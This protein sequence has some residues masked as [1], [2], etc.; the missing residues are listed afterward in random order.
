MGGQTLGYSAHAQL[1]AATIQKEIDSLRT[2][3][4]DFY[5][6]S[7]T[8]G[9]AP[10]YK[11][12]WIHVKEING[13]FHELKP[14]APEARKLMWDEFGLLCQR[15]KAHQSRAR[16]HSEHISERKRAI[17]FSKLDDA[18][19][20]VSVSTTPIDLAR[21]KELLNEA[22]GFM[23]DGWSEFNVSTQ[24]TALSDGRMTKNDH[25]KCWA[26][27]EDINNALHFRRRELGEHYC[28]TF[29]RDAFDAIDLAASNPRQ[30]KEAVKSI[31]QAMK[32]TVMSREQF[33]EV[34]RLLDEAWKRASHHQESRHSEWLER[35]RGNVSYKQSLIDKNEEYI[36]RL[37]AQI[38]KCQDMES[39]ARSEDFANTVRGWIEEKYDKIANVRSR[40]ADL[41]AEIRE[42]EHKLSG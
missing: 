12:F 37:E 10:D 38:E 35:Q 26:K 7:A 17:V 4:N 28:N 30:C 31:Q 20:Q 34:R 16:E 36:S 15:A 27:W 33:D 11:G 13:L 32:G 3:V 8:I 24:L 22:L 21:A 29:K 9:P 1:N 5:W 2:Q 42:I 39:D 18:H 25:Q 40:I 23:R 6:I 14:L 41:E 19:T